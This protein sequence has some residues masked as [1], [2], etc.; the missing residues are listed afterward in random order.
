MIL[1]RKIYSSFKP[2]PYPERIWKVGVISRGD[3]A[4]LR[5]TSTIRSAYTHVGGQLR[6]IRLKSTVI[7][8]T[9][10]KCCSAAHD[11]SDDRAT[12]R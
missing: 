4:K 1:G 6:D 11:S 3:V 7:N 5:S 8:R 10:A 12:N 2:N 9:N